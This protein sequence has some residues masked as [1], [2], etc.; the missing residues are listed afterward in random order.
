MIDS[1]QRKSQSWASEMLDAQESAGAGVIH[2]NENGAWVASSLQP[3][4]MI[5]TKRA[6]GVAARYQ[7]GSIKGK[8][9]ADITDKFLSQSRPFV[10]TEGGVL[11]MAAVFAGPRNEPWSVCYVGSNRWKF[12]GGEFTYRTDPE[13][14]A[15]EVIVTIPDEVFT[16]SPNAPS[17]IGIAFDVEWAIPEGETA[18]QVAIFSNWRV[19][20]TALPPAAN[21]VLSG[22]VAGIGVAY[23]DIGAPGFPVFDGFTYSLLGEPIIPLVALVT[24]SQAAFWSNSMVSAPFYFMREGG[25]LTWWP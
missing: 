19:T 7:H 24:D 20:V 17:L 12:I 15:T 21:K 11:E 8:P 25:S 9:M 14:E 4:G 10:S 5:E 6:P 2:D 13:D 16:V 3:A 18:G 22:P 23:Y 1:L